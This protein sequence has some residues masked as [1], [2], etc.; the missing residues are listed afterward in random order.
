MLIFVINMSL[1]FSR[2]KPTFWLFTF[3]TF[4]MRALFEVTDIEISMQR[5]TY[6]Y[7]FPGILR[8]VVAYYKEFILKE[9]PIQNLLAVISSK[10]FSIIMCFTRERSN[11]LLSEG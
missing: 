1:S 11:G 8:D 4:E 7:K 6:S 9:K 3:K 2:T 10:Q 5:R